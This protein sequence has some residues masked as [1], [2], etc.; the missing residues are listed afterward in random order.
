[1]NYMLGSCKPLSILVARFSLL[2][3]V[4]ISVPTAHAYAQ[5]TLSVPETSIE[6]QTEGIVSVDMDVIGDENT[7]GFSVT[8][9]T[10]QFTFVSVAPSP[11]LPAGTTV[12]TNE[13]QKENGRVGIA[14]SLPFGTS[15]APGK[16]R[17]VDIR[18]AALT[19]GNSLAVVGFGDQPIPREFVRADASNIPTS[20]VTLT[21][22]TIVIFAKATSASA[23]S[24]ST[25]AFAPQ[26]IVAVFGAGL[27]TDI[28]VAG[29]IPLPTSLAGT[30]IKF[31]DSALVSKNAPLFFVSPGQCNYLIPD[32]VASGAAT[33][34]VT[35]AD[36]R[37]SIG[38][39]FIAPVAPGFF[40]ANVS[41]TGVAAAQIYRIRGQ[42]QLIEEVASYQPGPNAF[43][44]NPIDFG[45]A[46]DL[47]VLVLYGTGL[48]FNSGTG[49]VTVTIGGTAVSVL[50]ANAAP[51]YVGLDQVNV[52]VLPRSLAGRGVVDIVV[53]VDGFEANT[54]TMQFK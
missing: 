27:A 24:Y 9:N 41:G 7:I 14:V 2:L 42:T 10:T 44:A 3:F 47:L 43:I 22:G 39:V 40:S 1:M 25:I 52:G 18:L 49:G 51:G 35:S 28:A 37:I 33:I 21:P 5:R 11:T 38:N 32:G 29:S 30:T 13:L 36:G 4:I 8:F 17:L 45:P 50:Y 19:T 23:A 6:R 20:A 34:T 54:L 48:R 53:K 46:E 15:F 16:H 31:V 26:S 12:L